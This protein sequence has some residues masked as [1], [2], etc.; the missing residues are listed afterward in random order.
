[1]NEIIF[2][3]DSSDA[4]TDIERLKQK[5]PLQKCHLNDSDRTDGENCVTLDNHTS[6]QRVGLHEPTTEFMVIGKEG[7][8]SFLCIDLSNSLIV[9]RHPHLMNLFFRIVNDPELH[10]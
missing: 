4:S 9:T 10:E 2:L 5:D 1:M 6:L 7:A 8:S 3:S